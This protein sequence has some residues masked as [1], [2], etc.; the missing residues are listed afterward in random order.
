MLALL[1][2][3]RYLVVWAVV[4]VVAAVCCVAGVWQ[5]QRLDEKHA[6]NVELRANSHDEPLDVQSVLP[7]S[8]APGSAQTAK[9][10]QFRRVRATGVYDVAHQVLV[11]GQTVG[12]SGEGAGELG[13][14]VLTPL[15]LGTGDV[16]LVVR[17]FVKAT[18]GA[19]VTPSVPPPPA[20]EVTVLGRVEP[21]ESK[22]DKYGQLPPGQVDSVNSAEAAARLGAT[23]LAGYVELEQDQPGG[24]GLIA[25]PAPDLSNPAGGAI[26]PQH[27]AYVIQWFL[28]ALLAL[29]LPFVLA[30]ADLKAEASKAAAN[31]RRAPAQDR[32]AADAGHRDV[33]DDAEGDGTDL[34]GRDAQR[35]AAKL[36]DRYGR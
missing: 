5:W 6:V 10:A 23:V 2:R 31:A 24:E 15:R 8:S 21:A 7:E 4:A 12:S 36:A 20:G 17:G 19:T 35:R 22:H 13:F 32:P 34:P 33:P 3:P 18:E 27:L 11:R 16:V 25:I 14:L 30:R 26:E 28:F 1:V 29:V 9:D